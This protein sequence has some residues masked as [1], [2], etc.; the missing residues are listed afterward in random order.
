MI[1]AYRWLREFTTALV[2]WIFDITLEGAQR[3]R[4]FLL[5]ILVIGWSGLALITHDI[6]WSQWRTYPL[7][8][9][10]DLASAFFAADVIRH[11]L[12]ILLGYW[13]AFKL[14]G[15]YLDDVFELSDV[16]VAERFIRQAAFA[17]SYNRISIQDGAIN[18]EDK[19]SPIY[20]IGGPGYVLMHLENAALFENINGQPHVLG[21]HSGRSI[22]ESFERLRQVID[23][24][25]Q[26]V[27]MTVNGRSRD[28]I[29]VTAKDVRLIFSV[30]RGVPLVDS[31][32]GLP[33]PFSYTEDAIKNLVYKHDS[34]PWTLTVRALI[35]ANL[36]R[37]IAQHTLSEFLANVSP[38]ESFALT[39][40]MA[41][42][43]SETDP[44]QVKAAQ[45]GDSAAKTGLSGQD[46]VP[47]DQIT[48]LFY[49]FTNAF[50]HQTAELGVELK[51]IGLG[52]W[53][54][55]SDIIPE[56]H[57]EAWQLSC[58]NQ[59]LGNDLALLDVRR[60][61][62]TKELMRLIREIP[63]TSF[64]R[65]RLEGLDPDEIGHELILTYREKLRN[66][67][68]IYQNSDLTPPPELEA[69]LRHLS[70]LTA[71]WLA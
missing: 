17:S 61:S 4:N 59:I 53:I 35:R 67:W 37:F 44:N 47:R 46:F 22:L 63:I 33:Q 34:Q 62:R 50:T 15:V 57:L 69:S 64:E 1:R 68:E 30:H 11:I 36:R 58:T 31:Q 55:P 29:D 21:S 56:Q 25:D 12:V 20:R 23:L 40:E 26:V 32:S 43:S 60:E 71:R 49:D 27:D 2:Q 70:R 7:D 6:G 3:R 13:L 19:N 24:R 51:W 65:M 16:P 38:I 54:T 5:M 10:I 52:T 66:A 9:L 41:P 8:I 14:A 39:Q 42:Q 45:A 18:P 28:G 48:N